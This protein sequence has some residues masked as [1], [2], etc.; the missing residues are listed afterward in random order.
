MPKK[1]TFLSRNTSSM[2]ESSG[3]ELDAQAGSAAVVPAPRRRLQRSS[4][5]SQGETLQKSAVSHQVSQAAPPSKSPDENSQQPLS[6]VS[7]VSSNS[8]VETGEKPPSLSRDRSVDDQSNESHPEVLINLSCPSTATHSRH[9]FRPSM[10]TWSDVSPDRSIPQKSDKRD[11]ETQRERAALN[12]V[13]L[14]TGSFQNSDGED[15]VGTAM[16][17][18]ELSLPQSIVGEFHNKK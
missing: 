13:I 18:E 11:D 7:Q 12:T 2:S 1:R 9:N 16:R 5:V 3:L 15:S 17:Q 4:S 14:Y 8:S 6:N 10:N